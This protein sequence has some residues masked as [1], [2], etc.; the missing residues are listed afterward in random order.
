LIGLKQWKK[1]EVKTPAYRSIEISVCKL[2]MRNSAESPN[3]SDFKSDL[4]KVARFPTAGQEERRLSGEVF[5]FQFINLLH[6]LQKRTV[7]YIHYL[8]H[9]YTE[10]EEK[11]TYKGLSK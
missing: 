7:H 11:T 3:L 8:Q 1:E 2:G 6:Y 10:R 5:F 4:F 9:F